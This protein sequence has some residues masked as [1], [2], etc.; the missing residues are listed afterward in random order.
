MVTARQIYARPAP[1]RSSVIVLVLVSLLFTAVAVTA[2]IEKA[3][4]DLLVEVRQADARR[5]RQ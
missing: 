3:G 5:L 4:N 2:F 1:L